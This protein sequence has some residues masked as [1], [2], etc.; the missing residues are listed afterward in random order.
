[1]TRRILAMLV[2]SLII[3]GLLPATAAFAQA[4]ATAELTGNQV[5]F[6]GDT[7]F[8]VKVNNIEPQLIGRTINAVTITLPTAATNIVLRGTPPAA[9]NFTNVKVTKFSN[10]HLVTFKG[11][12]I[13]PQ[14]SQ[15]FSI[16]STVLRPARSDLSGPFTVQVS[17]NN[18]TSNT[19]AAPTA[20]G[21]L[22]AAVEALEILAGSLRPTAPV[23]GTKGVADRIGTAGQTI[24]YSFDVKNYA[25]EAIPVTGALAASD[26]SDRPGTVAAKSIA[27]LD[28]VATF[29]IPVA[30][31]A[32]LAQ[33]PTNLTA[34]ATSTYAGA[35]LRQDT[36]TVQVPVD[37]E[38]S[39]LRPPRVR[40]GLGSARE[41][42]VAVDKTGGPKFTLN[43][44]TLTFG[45]NSAGLKGAPVE[46][47]AN[48]ENRLLAYQIA[49]IDGVNG[50][51][52]ASVVNIGQDENLANYNLTR[53]AGVITIDNLV[54][55][56][57]VDQP[58]L[59]NGGLD[60]DGDALSAVTEGTK[61]TVS[62][63]AT[64]DDLDSGTL[65]V[66]LTPDAGTPITVPVTTKTE[67]D[68]LS[69]TG[70]V[71]GA[72]VTW[73]DSA[74]QFV[75]SAE[76]ADEATNLGSGSSSLTLI[77]QFKP[78]LDT[79]SGVVIAENRIRVDFDDQTGI[80]GAC[81][82]SSW[83]IN[84]TP[85][86][87]VEVRTGDGRLCSGSTP[88]AVAVA[89]TLSQ[90]GSRV[91]T[92][93]SKLTADDLPTVT[94]TPGLSESAS[95]QLGIYIAKDG[96]ANDAAQQKIITA[97]AL[98]PRIP[99]VTSLRRKDHVTNTRETAYEDV[100]EKAYY[101]NVGGTDAILATIGGV[102]R[103]YRIEVLDGAGNVLKSENAVVPTSIDPKDPMATEWMQDIT[104]PIGTTDRSYVRGIRLVSSVGRAGAQALTT[105]VLDSVNPIVGQSTLSGPGEAHARFAEKIVGGTDNTLDW[106]AA[107]TLTSEGEAR[108]AHTQVNDIDPI[109]GQ[110]LTMRR[111]VFSDIDETRFLGLVYVQRN[112]ASARYED[113]AGNYM[114]DMATLES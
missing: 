53:S 104:I 90:D 33:R 58:V 110:T 88:A 86:L 68:G 100:E 14:G 52:S 34:S 37:L 28:G 107:W 48:A 13:A 43:D 31:G 103:N 59:G 38:F 18:M 106:Y 5:V 60:V 63:K 30:L 40:S 55:K 96:A 74:T 84:D 42:S 41:F 65:R 3:F 87:V 81:D 66:T 36:F 39:N 83:Q 56:L 27:G 49:E 19:T 29:N 102:R 35:A 12:S 101:T 62:G 76:I 20:A 91:L 111:A 21:K 69:F 108:T 15:I 50:I 93:S 23:N 105:I 99:D 46:F 25:K 16:P 85:G 44:S 61:I 22:T 73:H 2:T 71:S 95:R 98:V 51:L 112:D 80:R 97:T 7:S 1:M 24:T 45:N 109:E 77:D 8:S 92:L 6:P 114:Q 26:T 11:G 64:A 4:S 79:K 113:R 70:S 72:T 10:T 17:S 78:V 89:R 94:Y 32:A 9:G 54:P 75:V 57:E 82:P 47:A 67:P